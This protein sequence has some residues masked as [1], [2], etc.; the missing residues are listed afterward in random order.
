M[1]CF[2]FVLIEQLT[3]TFFAFY[4]SFFFFSFS[5]FYSLNNSQKRS[6][7]IRDK[8]GADKTPGGVL[9]TNGFDDAEGFASLYATI[10]RVNHSCDPRFVAR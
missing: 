10:S 4:S 2:C 1:T 6:F 8:E 9:R 3:K 5:L 7:E